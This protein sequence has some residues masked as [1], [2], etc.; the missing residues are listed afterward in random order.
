MSAP[1]G[2]TNGFKKGMI[3]WNK[4]LKGFLKGHPRYGGRKMGTKHSAKTKEKISQSKK[5]VTPWN[6]GKKLHYQV[7]NKGIKVPQISGKNH[8]LWGKTNI[9]VSGNKNINWKGGISTQDKLERAKFRQSMHRLILERDGYKCQ[10]CNTSGNLQVDHIQSWADFKEL[11]FDP[12]NCRTLCAKCHY[13]LTFNKDMPSTIKG[14]GH[15]FI[16]RMVG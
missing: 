14:W 6:F 3:P 15:H 12:E 4:G 16:E 11:R 5:G 1:I 13:K 2:N 8:W 7:W 9:A 10:L